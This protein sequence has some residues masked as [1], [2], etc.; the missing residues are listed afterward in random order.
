M[1]LHNE[2]LARALRLISAV[3]I[4][5]K[6]MS[7]LLAIEESDR[8]K[9]SPQTVASYLEGVARWGG[10]LEEIILR[11]MEDHRS[12]GVGAA[13]SNNGTL[14]KLRKQ[15]EELKRANKDLAT[16]A[17]KPVMVH[18]SETEDD[19]R[20]RAYEAMVEKNKQLEEQ[21][22][23]HKRYKALF[24][25]VHQALGAKI[26]RDILLHTAGN[27]KK[28]NPLVQKAMKL[29]PNL[30]QFAAV[31]EARE[32][33]EAEN[34]QA[35][36]LRCHQELAD[37]KEEREEAEYLALQ[38][39]T[40]SDECY[41]AN[42][43][44]QKELDSTGKALDASRV[45]IGALEDANKSLRTRV[46]EMKNSLRVQSTGYKNLE[47]RFEYAKS[48]LDAKE[49]ELKNRD[50]QTAGYIRAVKEAEKQLKPL[51]AGLEE[52]ER[53]RKNLTDQVNTKMKE[54][55]EA[56][57][58]I[59]NLEETA[60]AREDRF[61]H[62][63]AAKDWSNSRVAEEGLYQLNKVRDSLKAE[64]DTAYSTIEGHVKRID[65]LETMSDQLNDEN[66]SLKAELSDK[67]ARLIDLEGLK[68]YQD[69]EVA[70]L[71]DLADQYKKRFT[72]L[73]REM[74]ETKRTRD[75]ALGELQARDEA[76]RDRDKQ[77]SALNDLLNTNYY[78]KQ[79][80]EYEWHLKEKSKYI[81]NL[82]RDV[83]SLNKSVHGYQMA[84]MELRSRDVRVAELEKE[85]DRLKKAAD[86]SLIAE[87]EM[88]DKLLMKEPQKPAK[89]GNGKVSEEEKEEMLELL[90]DTPKGVDELVE[91]VTGDDVVYYED[92]KELT[93]TLEVIHALEEEGKAVETEEGVWQIVEDEE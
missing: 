19:T 37:V 2:R 33:G 65:Y 38:Y 62:G 84:E 17:I 63:L 76:V 77:I 92:D 16:A 29:M 93:H 81:S 83:D 26:P 8:G 90:S 44:L 54:L 23:E 49:M 79:I 22:E 51:K 31:K 7:V 59:A 45:E 43:C 80:A 73:E 87:K 25:G 20:A 74:V 21:L 72:D 6:N 64:L 68:G 28:D 9:V 3:K 35:E 91:L 50:K 88:Q 24:D 14:E 57:A 48:S 60:Q 67:K 13:E 15:V 40:K 78:E 1:N 27:M 86:E 10:S 42:E 85:V 55:A 53:A 89:K 82:E 12:S 11:A 46:D 70:R 4:S 30:D 41:E 47:S 56:K 66:G 58:V 34:W 39:K 71:R 32:S 18:D 69:S 36:Y 5:A 52:N 61:G 75:Q